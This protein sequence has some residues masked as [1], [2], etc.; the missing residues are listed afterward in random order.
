MFV[1]CEAFQSYLIFLG[2][3]NSLL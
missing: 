1:L 3:A 2:K